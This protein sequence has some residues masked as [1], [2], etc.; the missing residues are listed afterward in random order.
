MPVVSHLLDHLI[1]HAALFPPA[2]LGMPDALAADRVARHGP[3]AALLGAFVCPASRLAELAG[4]LMTDETMPV[5]VLVDTPTVPRPSDAR[6]DLWMV[7]LARS[8]AEAL[9]ALDSAPPG[10][11]AYVEVPRDGLADEL[12]LLAS[13]RRDGRAVGAKVRCGGAVV[14]TDAELADFLTGCAARELPFKATMG[15]H[16]AVRSGTEHGFLNLL[17]AC[18]AALSGGDVVAALAER[19]PEKVVEAVSEPD[20]DKR[21]RTELLASYGSCDFGEPVAELTALGLLA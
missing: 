5:S 19:S 20:I 1:D 7:E 8:A 4:G 3:H 9:V 12:D 21:V 13:A 11:P 14:P 16:H 10:L 18:A 17:A 6:L 15:L 2:Q